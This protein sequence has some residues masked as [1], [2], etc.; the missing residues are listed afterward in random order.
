M[1]DRPDQV[2]YLD[3]N[4]LADRWHLSPRSLERWRWRRVGPRHVKIGHR[5]LYDIR[6]IEAY[7]ASSTRGERSAAG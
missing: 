1:R 5:V 3:Q 2:R 6:D 7:E 4:Q